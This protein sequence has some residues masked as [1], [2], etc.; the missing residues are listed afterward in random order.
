MELV[1]GSSSSAASHP[2]TTPAHLLP[3][4]NVLEPWK[5]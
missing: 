5:P 2:R 3:A 4:A 1:K